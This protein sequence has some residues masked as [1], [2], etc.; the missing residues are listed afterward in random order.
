MRDS[1]NNGGGRMISAS[2]STGAASLTC[3]RCSSK[4]RARESPDG[5]WT[6]SPRPNFTRAPSLAPEYRAALL[7]HRPTPLARIRAGTGPA[8]ERVEVVVADAL[9]LRNRALHRG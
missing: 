7:Q 1:L 2:K 9:A 6:E 5:C 3:S 4:R 8:R